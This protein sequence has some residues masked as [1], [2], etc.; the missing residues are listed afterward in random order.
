MSPQDTGNANVSE[1][2]TNGRATWGA[3]PGEM[4]TGVT[5]F[6]E[7]HDLRHRQRVGVRDGQQ[8]GTAAHCREPPGGAAVQLQ[9]RRP[10]AADH[11]HVAPEDAL[12]MTGAEGF[13][14]RLFRSEAAREM[15]RRL[16][17]PH[18]VRDFPF[19][20]NALQKPRPVSVDGADD[21]GDFG[22]VDAQADDVWHDQ[23]RKR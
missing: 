19:R 10:A 16:P 3:R 17:A 2:P 6:A 9:L 7:D 1:A 18:A 8:R 5:S 23:N 12:R 4:P 22:E 11:F 15:N 20:E 21:A 14:R 13:H